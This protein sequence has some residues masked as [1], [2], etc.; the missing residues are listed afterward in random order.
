MGLDARCDSSVSTNVRIFVAVQ[1]LLVL[2]EQRDASDLLLTIHVL[3]EQKGGRF[4]V[5]G[6]VRIGTVQ[7]LRLD[8][9]QI[10]I[11]GHSVVVSELSSAFLGFLWREAGPQ[12]GLKR[13]NPRHLRRFI[14]S[15]ML[16]GVLSLAFFFT[17]VP[18]HQTVGL[19]SLTGNLPHVH[20]LLSVF[21]LARLL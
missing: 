18:V 21:L 3:V 5:L 16:L 15:L 4:G 8:L 17:M 12:T 7:V 11:Y 10:L 14:A 1:G 19:A 2:L 13:S 9:V 6:G 20:R